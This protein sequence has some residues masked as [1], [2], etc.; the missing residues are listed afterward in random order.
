MKIAFNDHIDKMEGGNNMD[1][2]VSVI[3]GTHNHAHFLPDCLNSIKGQT[4]KDYEVIVVDN[5]STD[6]TKDVVEKYDWGKTRYHYQ[7][8]TGSIAG[9][10]DTGIRLAKGEYV[11]F[12][13]S[14]DV[15]Y[16]QK[17]EKIMEVFVKHPEIDIISHDVL[18]TKNGKPDQIAKAGPQTRDMFEQL[19]FFGNCLSGSATVV[20]EKAIIE[21]GGFGNNKNF[22]LI[23]DYETWLRL[24][25]QKKVF[26]FMNECLGEYRMHGTNLTY[27]IENY[28]SII[29]VIMYHFR[30]YKSN[31]PIKYIRLC[32]TLGKF[33]FEWAYKCFS[34][35]QYI[36]GVKLS[37]VSFL[38][39]P[40][41][42]TYK[43]LRYFANNLTFASL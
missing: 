23:E 21:G 15:W 12:L 37:F 6:N 19:L 20:K 24:A 27:K 18:V 22:F 3:I 26:S 17:L 16:E 1:P 25:Y 5:G 13:D 10:R 31:N 11:A 40:I 41:Y 43:I 36:K 2:K 35:R 14:D 39:N 9:S 29:N 30:N 32:N 28:P 38:C 42:F 7:A 33:Y 34:V 8:D 4:Y